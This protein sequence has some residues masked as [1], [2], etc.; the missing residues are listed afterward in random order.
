MNWSIEAKILQLLIYKQIKEVKK[1]RSYFH[2]TLEGHMTCTFMQTSC[3]ME[4]P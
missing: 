3:G 4:T 2:M 1:K